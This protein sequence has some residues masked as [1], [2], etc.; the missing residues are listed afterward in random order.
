[1]NDLLD[2]HKLR[3]QEV[4]PEVQCVGPQR[5]FDFCPRVHKAMH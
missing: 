4:V 1:M 3:I 2:T 5:M